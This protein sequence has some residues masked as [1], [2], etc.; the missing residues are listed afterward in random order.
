MGT[1]V[2]RMLLIL[3]VIVVVAG[4]GVGGYL[5]HRHRANGPHPV[6]AAQ[7]QSLRVDLPENTANLE[8]GLIQFTVSLQAVDANTKTEITELMP[9][10][11][12]AV[13]ASMRDFSKAQLHQS[14]GVLKLKA[15]IIKAVDARL[16]MGHITRVYFSTIVI[17]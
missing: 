17:Q 4:I 10:V 3:A 6:T 2:R 15:A 5:Y 11:Q 12:D 9:S 7:L 14:D 16:P 13:N 1:I 8:D